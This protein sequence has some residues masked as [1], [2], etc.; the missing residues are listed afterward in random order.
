M[1]TMEKLL[2]FT[3]DHMLSLVYL[4]PNYNNESSNEEEEEEEEDENDFVAEDHNVGQCSMCKEQIY[5]FHLCYYQCKDCD[6]SLHKFCAE[7]PINLQNHPLHPNHNLTLADKFQRIQRDS[8]GPDSEWTYGQE[9]EIVKRLKVRERREEAEVWTN[10]GLK[11]RSKTRQRP[12]QIENESRVP[13]SKSGLKS[14]T[15]DKD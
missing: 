13:R 11:W 4:H 10:V 14:E 6:Y 8:A 9:K 2:H 5:S 3:H 12:R 1:A 7:M 15:K